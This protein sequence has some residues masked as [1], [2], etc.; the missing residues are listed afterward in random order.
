[1]PDGMVF[2][3]VHIRAGACVCVCVCVCVRRGGGG[4]VKITM[5][6]QITQIT[7]GSCQET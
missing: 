3:H 4:G 6:R 2:G 7:R 5:N 1:M